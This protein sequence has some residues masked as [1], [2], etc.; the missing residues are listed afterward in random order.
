MVTHVLQTGMDTPPRIGFVVSKAV[1]GAVVRNRVTR[2][3]RHLGA[4]RVDTLPGGAAVVVRALPAAAEATYAGL[5]AD[6]DRALRRSCRP[7]AA[8]PGIP[9]E[10]EQ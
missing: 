3:L 10:S 8:Q 7:S 2:R 5:A 4:A 9:A 1:G 6:L